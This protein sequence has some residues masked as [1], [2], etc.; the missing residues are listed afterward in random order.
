MAGTEASRHLLV[1]WHSSGGSTRVLA[2]A[3]AE[4]ARGQEPGLRVSLRH[5]SRTGPQDVRGCDALVLATPEMLGTVA[6][7][8]KDCLE[9]CY[10]PLR[11]QRPGLPVGLVVVAGTDGHPSL[12]QLRRVLAGQGWREVVPAVHWITGKTPDGG[13]DV[14]PKDTPAAV[15]AAREMGAALAAGLVLGIY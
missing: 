4:A 2:D 3:L 15:A 14:L 7:Q 10:Y 9:R 1:V 8:M 13:T 12:Q 6:G 5:A 11:G